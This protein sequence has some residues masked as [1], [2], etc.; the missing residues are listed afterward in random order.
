MV[1]ILIREV[2]Q[3]FLIISVNFLFQVNFFISI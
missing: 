3:N 2:M 1:I